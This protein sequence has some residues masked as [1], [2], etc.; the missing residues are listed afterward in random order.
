[1]S[2]KRRVRIAA[3]YNAEDPFEIWHPDHSDE[4]NT[5]VS[6]RKAAEVYRAGLFDF[7][8]QAET[9]ALPS[10]EDGV[11][12]PKVIGRLDNLTTQS[13]LASLFPDLGFVA[14]INTGNNLPYDLARK[15]HTFDLLTNGRSGWNVVLGGNPKAYLNHRA[16]AV[17][18]HSVD[19]YEL[20]LEIVHDVIAALTGQ[21]PDGPSPKYFPATRK[22][23][24]P[25]ARQG[26][27]FTIQAGDSPHS[28]DLAVSYADGLYTHYADEVN[29]RAFYADVHER[30]KTKGR[31]PDSLKIYSRLAV[32]VG[33]NDAD[34]REKHRALL[35]FQ[36]HEQLAADYVEEIWGKRFTELDIEGPLPPDD[37][38]PGHKVSLGLSYGLYLDGPAE[39]AV[40]RLR[41]ISAENGGTGLRETLI[42]SAGTHYIFGGPVAVATELR[43]L[44]DARAT[45]GFVIAPH[46][47]PDWLQGFVKSVVPILQDWGVY[48]REYLD[49]TL[50]ERVAREVAA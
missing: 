6:F 20:G 36:L 46:S 10:N 3:Q 38:L 17:A 41:K 27:P 4:L 14:T 47:A 44:V 40:D 2:E 35:P 16:K 23:L 42:L 11:P 21:R 13:Y 29:G 34:A 31:Y 24:L 9:A 18:E 28:R 45:D 49:E 1:M 33:D 26:A 32:L 37:P 22:Q 12:E 7:Y 25:P 30:L 15:L 50:R 48:A 39:K 8:F 43:R 5:E 19:R